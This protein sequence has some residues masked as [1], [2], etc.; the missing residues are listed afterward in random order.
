MKYLKPLSF[1]SILLLLTLSNCNP[2][3]FESVKPIDQSTTDIKINGSVKPNNDAFTDYV[4]CENETIKLQVEY[5]DPNI[6]EAAK[7][8]IREAFDEKVTIIKI[9]PSKKC[10]NI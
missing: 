4:D 3:E 10:P 5:H 2:V 7:M 8:K 1:A 9:Y 6:T